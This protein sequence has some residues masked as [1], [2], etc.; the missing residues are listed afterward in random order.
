VL[1]Q[2]RQH[3]RWWTGILDDNP[4]GID[5]TSQPAGEQRAAHVTR[6]GQHK[7]AIKV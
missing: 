2:Q 4:L 6:A 7:C 1:R 3:R 5:P